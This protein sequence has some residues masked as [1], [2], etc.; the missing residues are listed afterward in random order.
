MAGNAKKT[1]KVVVGT[2]PLIT[3]DP[4]I[5]S[6]KDHPFFEKKAATAKALLKKVGLPK[7]LATK[8]KA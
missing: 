3:V 8:T 4:A 7:Q 2:Q 1:K 6:F 5:P